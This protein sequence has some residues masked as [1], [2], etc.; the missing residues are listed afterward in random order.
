M[1]LI[2]G[3]RAKFWEISSKLWAR[4]PPSFTIYFHLPLAT[5]IGG[6]ICYCLPHPSSNSSFPSRGR[7]HLNTLFLTY[8]HSATFRSPV[9][10][11]VFTSPPSPIPPSP[12]S[13]QNLSGEK[14]ILHS[15]RART[16]TDQKTP[17]FLTLTL[18]LTR[19]FPS[20]LSV[21]YNFKLPG[22]Y[23]NNA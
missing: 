14:F 1:G 9:P 7:T 13:F 22:Q 20:F 21:L 12:N 16:F 18:P 4:F 2:I 3:T 19:S 15:S 10:L 17:L 6:R 5:G 8:Y 23:H 11:G